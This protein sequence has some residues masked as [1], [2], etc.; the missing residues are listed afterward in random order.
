MVRRPYLRGVNTYKPDMLIV[1]KDKGIAVNNITDICP[2][3]KT[4]VGVR[5][6]EGETAENTPY[7][8]KYFS[9]QGAHHANPNVDNIAYM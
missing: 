6:K 5:Y 1:R 3:G 4:I 9:A 2:F 7:I 8:Y